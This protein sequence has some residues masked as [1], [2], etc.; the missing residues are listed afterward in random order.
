MIN[1]SS[2]GAN[3]TSKNKAVGP[4]TGKAGVGRSGASVFE[5][6]ASAKLPTIVMAAPIRIASHA[7]RG[8]RN[9]AGKN[10]RKLSSSSRPDAVIVGCAV[11]TG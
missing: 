4:L 2:T 9:G 10:L 11:A 7:R 6:A 8:S 5:A 3:T 1:V